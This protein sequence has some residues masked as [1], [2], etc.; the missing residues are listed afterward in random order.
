MGKNVTSLNEL[1]QKKVLGKA[2]A[3]K[4]AR[5]GLRLEH[6][7]LAYR[8]QGHDGVANLLAERDSRGSLASRVAKP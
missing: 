6:L 7:Q 2:M 4:V 1:I 3:E 8:R 5:S